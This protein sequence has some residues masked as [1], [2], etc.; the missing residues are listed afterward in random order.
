MHKQLDILASGV[1]DAKNQLFI[2][3]S[4]I[5]ASE[6]EHGIEMAEARY[7]IESAA[8]R[9][10]RTLTAYH[11]L[12]QDAVAAITPAIVGDICDEVMLAQ[13]KHLAVRN[14]ALTVNCTVV[15]EWP[16]DRDLITDMLN[17]AVQNAGRYARQ[18][19][20]LSATVND[21]WLSLCVDDDGPGFTSLPPAQ[22]TGLMVAERLAQLHHRRSRQGSLHLS[23][24]GALGGA[25]FELRLP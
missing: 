17:N 20:C 15:D 16:L 22:G 5:A 19:V 10:S 1:H 24:H 18:E 21:G 23:N 4:L 25:R 7:A 9:L 2:A 13:Q 11:L 6:A 8:T 3:E 14:I 12:R